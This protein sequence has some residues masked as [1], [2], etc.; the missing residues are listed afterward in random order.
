M[1]F[2]ASKI[3]GFFALPSNLVITFG[4][5]GALLLRTRYARAGWRLVVLS[6]VLLA[7]I[8]FS[9]IGNVMM[10]RLEQRFP[11]W[12]TSHGPPVGIVVLGGALSPE[13]S[14]AR[15]APALNES[16]ER[17]TAAVELARRY[18]SA[19][20]VYSGGSGSLLYPDAIEADHAQRLFESLGL[21]RERILIE[22]K[23]RN[24]AENA[25]FSKALANPKP[26]ERWLL[27]TSAH[28]MPRAIA[29]FRRIG[30]AV[31][32]HP[33]DWRTRGSNDVTEPFGSIA[34]GLARTD[35]AAKEY[36]GLFVYWLTGR[37]SELWPEP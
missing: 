15:N 31:D 4:I 36:V 27:I 26:G 10:V 8:G 12:D 22:R 6:L 18:P 13:I 25:L 33:V 9:P 21:A 7:I 24:T 29:C 37:I 19:R 14:A 20:I 28:H 32:A 2:T 30:F 11:A 16:A 1:F 35:A 5:L 3:L 34:G 17:I 23:A